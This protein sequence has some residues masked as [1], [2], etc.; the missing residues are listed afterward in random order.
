MPA[1]MPD[2]YQDDDFWDED[3]LGSFIYV[4]RAWRVGRHRYD[5]KSQARAKLEDALQELHASYVH[6]PLPDRLVDVVRRHQ[7]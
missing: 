4:P 1:G 5:A 7:G 2:T 3:G 6:L